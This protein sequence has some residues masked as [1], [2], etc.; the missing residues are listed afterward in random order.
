MFLKQ[1]SS[2]HNKY[3]NNLKK[4]LIFVYILHLYILKIKH[5]CSSL[6]YQLT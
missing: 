6:N 3:L 2:E 5:F 4:K 1:N